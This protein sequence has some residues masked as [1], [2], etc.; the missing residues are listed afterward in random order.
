MLQTL[1]PKAHA[2]ILALPT[3]GPIADA[4]D[5]WLI[6]NGYTDLSRESAIRMLPHVDAALGKRHVGAME[7][8]T[9]ATFHACWRDVTKACSEN[10]RIVRSLER[11]LTAAGILAAS[12]PSASATTSTALTEEYVN[13]LRE[14]RGFSA[15]TLLRHRNTARSFLDRLETQQVPLHSIK[16]AHIESYISHVGKRVS[17]ATL[18]HDVAVV[19]GLLRFLAVDHKVPLGLG[20]QIDSP[21]LYE[22]EKLPRALPWDTVTELLKSI[23]TESAMGLRNYAML[24]MLA[25]YGLRAS[26]VVAVTLDDIS[27]RQRRLRI[28]QR[29]TRSP[30]ELPLTNEVSAALVKHLKRTPP[31]APHRQIFLRMRAPLGLLKPTAI[32]EVLQSVVRNS[33]LDIPHHGTHCLRHSLAVHLLKSGTPIKTIGDILGHLSPRSTSVYL[34]L[35]SDDLRD[36]ALTVPSCRVKGTQ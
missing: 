28:Y 3:L 4:Y 31:P 30:L 17:R 6:A 21:R 26:E 27:W 35:A 5:D 23:D 22:M 34:R 15:N 1:L 10:A 11:Y 29:K 18:Q 25:T 14:V 24:L 8:L 16:A 20:E 12:A 33:R 19:R 9:H 7:H 2:K 36:V 32:M 13:F